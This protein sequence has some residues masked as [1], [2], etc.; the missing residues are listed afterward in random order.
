MLR[1]RTAGSVKSGG[2]QRFKQNVVTVLLLYQCTSSSD[3]VIT[4]L[5]MQ[6]S[7]TRQICAISY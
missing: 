4:V 5:T 7:Q 2:N 3:A 1:Q 6:N